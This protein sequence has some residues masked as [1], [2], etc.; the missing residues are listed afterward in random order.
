MAKPAAYDL[1]VLIRVADG[2]IVHI[3]FLARSLP[4]ADLNATLLEG[5]HGTL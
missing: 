4:Y 3:T 1:I 2:G 5:G